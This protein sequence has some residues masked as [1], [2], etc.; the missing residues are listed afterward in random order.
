MRVFWASP[1]ISGLVFA[2]LLIARTGKA[3]ERSAPTLRDLL[4]QKQEKLCDMVVIQ[5]PPGA[6]A[7]FRPRWGSDSLP[8]RPLKPSLHDSLSVEDALTKLDDKQLASCGLITPA[9]TGDDERRRLYEILLQQTVFPPKG[10]FVRGLPMQ[11][12]IPPPP[13]IQKKPTKDWLRRR[14]ADAGYSTQK[15]TESLPTNKQKFWYCLSS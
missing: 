13:I 5:D 4:S 7:Y 2:A 12:I 9:R 14:S 15:L 11:E 10:M 3:D 8:G 6:R 1:V